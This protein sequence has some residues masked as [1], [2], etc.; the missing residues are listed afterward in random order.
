MIQRLPKRRILQQ[1]HTHAVQSA[2]PHGAAGKG[3]RVPA[4]KDAPQGDLRKKRA[5]DE[6]DRRAGLLQGIDRK[7]R[8]R[9]RHLALCASVL[10][11]Q[12]GKFLQAGGQ[13]ESHPTVLQLVMLR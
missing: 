10:R 5:G 11:K 2:M 8:R 13:Q 9:H 7:R 12:R 6:A 1:L 3:Q 4:E